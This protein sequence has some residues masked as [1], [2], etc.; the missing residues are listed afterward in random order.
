MT[1]FEN[2]LAEQ[3]GTAMCSAAGQVKTV[4]DVTQVDCQDCRSEVSAFV[5]VALGI[6]IDEDYDQSQLCAHD[7]DCSC[8]PVK[9]TYSVRDLHMIGDRR[10]GPD[11]ASH[12][13]F[14][15]VVAGLEGRKLFDFKVPAVK[16]EFDS[17]RE[18]GHHYLKTLL[19]HLDAILGDK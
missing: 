12:E 4:F 10:T 16:R 5:A 3:Y 18:A 19:D 7:D 14:R 11:Q 2:P 13:V 6:Q 9:K 15:S 1:H 8:P 17:P